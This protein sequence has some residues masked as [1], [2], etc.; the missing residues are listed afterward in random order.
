MFNAN[1]TESH[2]FGI[3][4]DCG[5]ALRTSRSGVSWIIRLVAKKFMSNSKKIPSP[6]DVLESYLH[7]VDSIN[8]SVPP[9]MLMLEEM[10][11]IQDEKLHAYL[12]EH[13]TLE[14]SVDGEETYS[15]PSKAVSEQKRISRKLEQ[16]STSTKLIPRNFLVSFVSEYDAFLG[17]LM[18]CFHAKKPELL[19]GV[20][21]QISYSE[22]VEFSSIEDAKEHILEKDVESMLRKSHADHFDILEKKFKI[23]LKKDLECWADFIEIMERRNLFVHCDGKISSQYINV[24]TEHKKKFDSPPK[25]G[26]QLTVHPEYLGNAY[27]TLREISIKLTHVLWRKVFPDEREAADDALL[28]LAYELIQRASYPLAINI[29]EFA[30]S[31]PHHFSDNYKRMFFINLAQA[32]KYSE[33]KDKCTDLLARLDWSSVSYKFKLAVAVLLEKYHDADVYMANAAKTGELTEQNFLDWP[34]FKEYRETAGFK[35]QFKEQFKKSPPENSSA[36]VSKAQVTLEA[37]PHEVGNMPAEAPKVQ[38]VRQKGPVAARKST[39]REPV[40]KA[41]K[42]SKG[43]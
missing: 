30:I 40:K 14:S 24:C 23:N 16:Y 8:A 31:L 32:Y 19:N 38:R 7:N 37:V 39:R 9:M 15:L 25:V 11:R 10:L 17:S 36:T 22:L 43:T 26:E 41:A 12:K 42:A 1:A 35:K 33:K 28:N 2:A 27:K 21:K 34:L 13:G 18:K 3:F 6:H 5:G 29:L 20:E 4:M